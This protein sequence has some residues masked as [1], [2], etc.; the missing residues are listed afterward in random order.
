ML[1]SHIKSEGTRGVPSLFMWEN[2]IMWSYF[3]YW[4]HEASR[5]PKDAVSMAVIRT[6]ITQ[7]PAV[8]IMT[9]PYPH[10]AMLPFRKFL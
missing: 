6:L 4:I 3:P 2:I 1:F 10:N 8:I 5:N 9:A 7:V